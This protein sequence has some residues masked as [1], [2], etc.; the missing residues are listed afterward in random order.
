M[1]NDE[2][3]PH[4]YGSHGYTHIAQRTGDQ[5]V[6]RSIGFTIMRRHGGRPGFDGW[7]DVLAFSAVVA[8]GVECRISYVHVLP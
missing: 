8:Q 2:R 7:V 3:I 5:R 4:C 1:L 6:H